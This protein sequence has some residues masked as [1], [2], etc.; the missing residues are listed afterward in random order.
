M[1]ACEEKRL[2]HT[3][4]NAEKQ[5]R[6]K[7]QPFPQTDMWQPQNHHTHTKNNNKTPAQNHTKTHFQAET[8]KYDEIKI[9]VNLIC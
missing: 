5:R 9:L 4:T 8:L 1:Q 6:S 7:T 2:T 3:Q